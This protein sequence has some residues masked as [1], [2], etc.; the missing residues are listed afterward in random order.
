ME[1]NTI[2][3]LVILG[4]HPNK[5]KAAMESIANDYNKYNIN[6]I[7]KEINYQRELK[8]IRSRYNTS[9][10]QIKC[11]LCY[12]LKHCEFT[13]KRCNNKHINNKR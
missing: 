8:S 7:I 10:T 11:P 3:Q 12:R 6:E 9:N 5:I 4:F 13:C 1:E 2:N